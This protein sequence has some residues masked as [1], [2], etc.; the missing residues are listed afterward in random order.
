MEKTKVQNER[1]VWLFFIITFIF[2]WVLWLPF[3]LWGFDVIQ[4]SEPTASL[5]TPAVMLGAFGPLIAALILIIWKEGKGGVKEFFRN[6]FDLRVKPVFYVLALL[7]PL[8]AT[9]A[10]H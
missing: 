5:M 9:S 2:S 8:L 6:A 3:V 7:L 1:N 4:L 10:A